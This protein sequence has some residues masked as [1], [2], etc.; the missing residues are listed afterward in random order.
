[1]KK[2]ILF[3]VIGVI[4][5]GAGI[6]YRYYQ[7]QQKVVQVTDKGAVEQKMA[8][9]RVFEVPKVEG[10]EVGVDT[11]VTE[12]QASVNVEEKLNEIL[13]LLQE[14]DQDLENIKSRLTF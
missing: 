6:G 14:A 2:I 12:E 4:V 10:T 5:L 8:G 7:D 9:E 1:M 13:R 3:I 11:G